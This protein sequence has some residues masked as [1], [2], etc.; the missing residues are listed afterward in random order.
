MLVISDDVKSSVLAARQ[1][2]ATEMD[3]SDSRKRPLDG[4]VESGVTKRSNPG[5]ADHVHFKILIPSVAAGAIIG[6]GGETLTQKQK[7]TGARVK[8]SKANDFYPATME[9]V[10]LITGTVE[11][12]TSIHNFIME[13]IL[14]KPDPNPKPVDGELKVNLE[15]HKQVKIL[16][17]NSTAGMIIGKAG[18]Y[19]KTVKEESG[20][21]VQVS[22][23]AKDINLPE[24]CVTISGDMDCNKKAVAMILQKIAEDPQSASC[25]NISYADVHGPVCSSNPTGSPFAT[26]PT[27]A[28][29]GG[30]A[31][32]Q[33][34]AQPVQPQQQPGMMTSNNNMNNNLGSGITNL[35]LSAANIGGAGMFGNAGMNSLS[36]ENL[37]ATLRGSGYSDQATDD[38]ST[39]MCTL[40]NY[41]FLGMGMGMGGQQGGFSLNLGGGTGLGGLNL[42]GGAANSF[43]SANM[44]AG[45]G[46]VESAGGMF[47]PVGSGSSMGAGSAGGSSLFSTSSANPVVDNTSMF[48]EAYNTSAFNPPQGYGSVNDT[49]INQNSFGLSLAGQFSGSGAATAPQPLQDMSGDKNAPCK[50]EMEV[51]ENLVGVILGPGGKGINE[52]KLATQA[53]IQISKKGVFAPGTRNRIVTITATAEHV[54]RAYQVIQQKLQQEESKRARQTQGQPVR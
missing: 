40:A 45:G 15:R 53:N 39:A 50:K 37:K 44:A 8:M 7:E 17:P 24:R 27:A 22:Q 12:I 14:E 20:A 10:C 38:I 4:E 32:G 21:Y 18:N 3:T 36:L 2:M 26:N 16:V 54:N 6:K 19:I 42:G 46:T 43:G 31:E 34:P 41:G 23:K 25:P 48:T 30:R 49:V 9:R 29:T 51:P 28:T 35:N 13:K 52:L 33:C 1:R 11:A 5:G 47:G